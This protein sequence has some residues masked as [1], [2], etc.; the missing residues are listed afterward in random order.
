MVLYIAFF[1]LV[2]LVFYSGRNL[3]IYGDILA[4]KFNLGRSLFGVIFVASITSLPELITGISS[5]T[6]AKSPDIAVSNIFGSCMFNFMVFAFVDFL[7]EDTPMTKKVHHGLS[8]SAAFGI[9]L[10]GI[11]MMPLWLK[12]ELTLGWFSIFSVLILVVYMIAISVTSS[13]EKRRMKK[14]IEKTVYEIKEEA[15]SKKEAVIQYI[16]HSTVIIFAAMLLPYLGKLIAI[17]TGI[18]ESFIGGILLGI[19]TSLPEI[20]V[21]MLAVK[22]DMVEMAVSNILGSNIFN[23]FTLTV[24]D[25]FFTKGSIFVHVSPDQGVL[26]TASIIMAAII[27]IELIYR[28]ERKALGRFDYESLAIVAVYLFT[29]I[30]IGTR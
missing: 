23:I 24:D 16:I 25:L 17:E 6:I 8:L 14:M 7:L 28:S 3:L 11:A 9:I 1:A 29:F 12:K 10:I 5:V 26:A 27:M 13:Y 18:G 20:A 19:T 22:M 21:S 30:Y 15:I 4:D 2:V